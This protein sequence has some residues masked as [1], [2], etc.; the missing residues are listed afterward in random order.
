MSER[1]AVVEDE[2]N[3]RDNVAFALEREGYSVD[4]SGLAYSINR[5]IGMLIDTGGD[6][7]IPMTRADAGRLELAQVLRL[8]RNQITDIMTWL[9][10][11]RKRYCQS[12][13]FNYRRG[14]HQDLVPQL[15]METKG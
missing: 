2:Q 10:E 15:E 6:E 5:S 7:V 3:I 12:R 13:P 11:I 8:G 4:T 1:I 14:E 9:E